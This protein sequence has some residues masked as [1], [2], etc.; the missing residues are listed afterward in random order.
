MRRD[1]AQRL[2]ARTWSYQGV[3]VTGSRETEGRS[4]RDQVLPFL[5]VARNA[6]FRVDNG[7]PR[8]DHRSVGVFVTEGGFRTAEDPLKAQRASAFAGWQLLTR[9]S[10]DEFREQLQS[11]ATWLA[12][13]RGDAPR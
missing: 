3:L 13:S 8:V 2:A 12:L 7:V 10:P 1:A 4:I 9:P 11:A 6:S 5:S